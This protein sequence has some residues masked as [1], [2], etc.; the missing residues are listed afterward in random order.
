MKLSQ[1]I[2]KLEKLIINNKKQ[3]SFLFQA[4]A[5][6]INVLIKLNE[7]NIIDPTNISLNNDN[8]IEIHWHWDSG[9]WTKSLELQERYAWD[10][11]ITVAHEMTDDCDCMFWECDCRMGVSK[12]LNISHHYFSHLKQIPLQIINRLKIF[13]SFTNKYVE[14]SNLIF[15][16]V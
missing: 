12:G 8:E 11:I 16:I 5:N 9:D 3:N 10:M 7:F 4:G 6:I 13:E 1:Q 15:N 2:N 14:R